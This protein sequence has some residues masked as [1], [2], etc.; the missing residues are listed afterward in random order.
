MEQTV[1]QSAALPVLGIEQRRNL[2]GD[3]HTAALQVQCLHMQQLTLYCQF[4]KI[5]NYRDLFFIKSVHIRHAGKG[6]LFP[7]AQGQAVTGCLFL[8]HKKIT[9]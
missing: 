7:I 3:L 4:P 2:A 6:Q 8:F 5:R 1:K 9:R